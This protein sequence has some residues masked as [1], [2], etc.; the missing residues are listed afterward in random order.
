VAE[1]LR[2]KDAGNSQFYQGRMLAKHTAGRNALSDSCMEYAMGLQEL[3]K[4]DAMIKRLRWLEAQSPQD[5]PQGGREDGEGDHPAK[6]NDRSDAMDAAATQPD[7]STVL[8]AE[9]DAAAEPT[10]AEVEQTADAVR[11]A[12]YLN[13]A[14]TN[15]LLEEWTPALACCQQVLEVCVPELATAVDA[16]GAVPLEFVVSSGDGSD[17]GGGSG[18]GDSGGCDG[19]SDGDRR[20][21]GAA[22]SQN[23]AAGLSSPLLPPLPSLPLDMPSNSDLAAHP[24]AAVAAK[25]LYRRSQARRGMGD[26]AAGREDLRRALRIRPADTAI[27]REL[28]EAEAAAAREAAQE[29]LKK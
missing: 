26:A 7:G 16:G 10:L 28:E 2:R 15:L 11:P 12:L 22:N 6:G 18:D 14:A 8:N 3:A 19:G 9:S 27:R 24:L 13:L 21:A 1:A 17:S 4:A 5:Q 23:D 25:A 20:A 29:A